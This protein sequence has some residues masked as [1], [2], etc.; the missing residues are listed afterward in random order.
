MMRSQYYC[1]PLYMK[2]I[3]FSQSFAEFQVA[4]LICR[5]TIRIHSEA[6]VQE[7]VLRWLESN[8]SY[9]QRE[10]I[11]RVEASQELSQF[12]RTPECSG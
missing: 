2:K 6:K 4:E 12:I 10:K 5:D 3:C 7:C 9:F 11:T 8:E 1:L